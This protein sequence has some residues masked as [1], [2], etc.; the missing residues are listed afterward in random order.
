MKYTRRSLLGLLGAA[1]AGAVLLGACGDDEDGGGSSDESASVNWWHIGTDEPL[2]TYWNELSAAYTAAHPKVEIKQTVINNADFKAKL[3]P[4]IQAGDPPDIFHSWGGGALEQQVEARQLKD[5]T[6]KVSSWIESVSPVALDYYKV[7]GKIYGAPFD[8]GMVGFWYNKDLF[9]RAGVTTP[10][11]TWSEF[12]QVVSKLK[13]ANITPIALGGQEKWPGHFYWS[14][15]SIRVGGVNI[16]RDAAKAKN[17]DKPELVQAGAE[18]KK[19]VDLQPFQKG[20]LAATYDKPGGQAATM[21]NGEAAMELMGQWAPSVEA[22]KSKDT[23]GIGADKT[24]FFPFPTV[25]GGKGKITDAFGGGNGYAIGKD[26]PDAAIDF[27][28][29]MLTPEQQ[30]KAGGT[31]AVIPVVKDTQDS[32]KDPLQA[33]VAKHLKEA[34]GFQMYLDQA[35]P[36]A[37]GEEVNNSVAKL[38]AGQASPEQVVKSITDAAKR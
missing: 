33:I 36:P 28:K 14:Y 34:T 23:K 10:P 8:L 13:A 21:G 9:A 7:D 22:A 5:I 24:G 16:L 18:L 3:T 15:L 38:I 20:F 4:A 27:L 19:L 32:V 30:R 1:G 2:K 35:F 37:I 29:F 6:N 25:D 26:A 12:L 11:A 17:F 31:G